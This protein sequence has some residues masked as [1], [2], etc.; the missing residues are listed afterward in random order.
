MKIQDNNRLTQG[1]DQF[2][3]VGPDVISLIP[4]NSGK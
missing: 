2:D 4:E 1:T 3:A